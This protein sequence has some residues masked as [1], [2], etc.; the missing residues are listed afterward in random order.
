M[1]HEGIG[2]LE[3]WNTERLF[4]YRFTNWDRRVNKW[5]WPNKMPCVSARCQP[6]ISGTEN[7]LATDVHRS[8]PD[9]GCRKT[10]LPVFHG[11]ME[12][13]ETAGR[14]FIVE[15]RFQLVCL[16]M[17]HERKFAVSC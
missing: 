15:Q 6:Q 13:D 7:K 3:L 11:S 2:R 14:V 1:Q 17:E 16:Y 12:M 10:Q 5:R 9:I 4:R 8:D